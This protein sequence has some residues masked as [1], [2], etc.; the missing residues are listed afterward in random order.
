ML[1]TL[2]IQVLERFMGKKDMEK[3]LDS[4]HQHTI[5]KTD[6]FDNLNKDITP[7][8]ANCLKA[9]TKRNASLSE[10]ARANKI[11]TVEVGRK[12]RNAALKFYYQSLRSEL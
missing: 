11:T 7:V 9:F 10:I 4:Y 6:R 3:L 5:K 1:K 2:R 12:A 8:E